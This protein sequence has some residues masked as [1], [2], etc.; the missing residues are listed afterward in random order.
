MFQAET[1]ETAKRV[2][3]EC[4]LDPSPGVVRPPPAPVKNSVLPA[5]TRESSRTPGKRSRRSKRSRKE[6]APRFFTLKLIAAWSIVLAL[7]VLGARK[8]WHVP[9]PASPPTA[10]SKPSPVPDMSEQDIELLKNAGQR[11]A[12]SFSGFLAAGTPEERN[13]FVLNPITTASRMARFYSL[14]PIT[15]LDP[16]S[17]AITG[18]SIMRIPRQAAIETHWAARDGRK[19]DAVF[20]EENGEWRLDWDHFARF[21]DYP[22]ALFL[23]GSGPAEGEFRLLARERLAT[24]RKNA[25]TIS[26]ALYAPKF[27]Q[28]YEAGFQSPEFLVARSSPEGVLLE[29]A[30]QLA[31]SGTRVFGSSLPNLNPDDMIRVR[32]KVRRTELADERR[33]EITG[34][35]ACHW[36]TVDDPGVHP[37]PAK[38]DKPQN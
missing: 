10:S 6:K 34:V 7:I 14:N 8:M 17:L 35:T 20:R 38:P 32:V 15:A 3:P 18:T 19:F 24:E 22:W 33:F 30:F 26:L 31:R 11:C 9:T 29:A 2:C 37:A 21:S 28:P 23:A 13:Q 27:G 1:G 25:D 5:N 12:D 4:G 16:R 36:L